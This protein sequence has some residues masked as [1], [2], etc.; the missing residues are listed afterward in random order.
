MPYYKGVLDSLI[1]IG[2]A[3]AARDVAERLLRLRT[4]LRK[5]LPERNVSKSILIATWN[6]R[7]FGRNRM[8]GER[9]DE[10][11]LFIAEIVSHFDLIAV[12]EVNQDLGDLQRLMKL[13]GNWWEYIVTDVTPGQ[14]G[15][16][17]RIAFIYD[18]R[19]VLFDHLAGELALA[20]DKRPVRQPARSPFICAFRTGWR[21]VSLCSV[22]IYYGT[23]NPNDRR[24]VQE[25]AAISKLLAE[26][27]ERRQSVA[28]GEP[29]N[30]VLLV[31]FN[32]FRKSGDKTS[33]ALADNNFI[34]PKPIRQLPG[35]N[36]GQD[37]Y[38][39]QIAFHDPQ[40][41]LRASCAGVFDFTKTIYGDDEAEA[42]TEAIKRSAPEHYE[43]AKD[44]VMFYKIW[45]TFQ[46]SDHL[47]LWLE[48]KTDFADA[49]LATVMR[50]RSN[51]S[52]APTP[53]HIPARA[54]VKTR[55]RV[56]PPKRW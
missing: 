54:P 16:E 7:E 52:P 47:P 1:E 14:S 33:R 30:V 32:I 26:R 37:K 31:D 43:K 12:Q 22:H 9:L 17:E 21:R 51:R 4:R 3:K 5:E 44:K 11:L 53:D 38:F 10:S 19:K 15:N 2:C 35:S 55:R 40:Q 24:R 25:I 41:R 50:G 29:E 34:V 28:D 48:L 20:A 6:L 13:L 56:R 36:L 46:I 8:C 45:R 39:D 18:S 23:R 27:N 49:Y 42:Y